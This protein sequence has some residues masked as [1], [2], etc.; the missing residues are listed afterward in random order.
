LRA[1]WLALNRFPHGHVSLIEALADYLAPPEIVIVREQPGAEG[2]WQNELGKL[3]A[4]QR[5]VF[6][7]PA[8]SEGLDAA[9]ADKKPGAATRAYVCRG[10]TCS[11]PIESL[12]DLIR[13][14]R[15]SSPPPS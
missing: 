7:I 8:S 15:A 3:Y 13:A 1:S 10:S 12:A 2:A 4:P 9:L 6:S 5:M 14:A 11:P